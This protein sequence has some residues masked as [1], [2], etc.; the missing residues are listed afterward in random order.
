MKPRLTIGLVTCLTL[1]VVSLVLWFIV[2]RVV[3]WVSGWV[4]HYF[5][6]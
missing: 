3:W 1:T 2:I 4:S 5:N 6:S